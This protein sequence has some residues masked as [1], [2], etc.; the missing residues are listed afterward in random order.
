M[1]GTAPL[2]RL[3]V[4]RDEL[5]ARDWVI[6]CFGF[7]YKQ[8]HY[9]VLV[10][11]YV[12]PRKAPDRMLVQL[13]F[14]DAHDPTRTLTAPANTV[15]IAVDA[16]ELRVFLGISW[17]ENLGDLLAQFYA[18]LGRFVP[19]R[20]PEMLDAAARTVVLRE[21]SAGDS[22]DPNKVYCIG[23]RRNTE[24]ADGTPG[25]RS[26]YN[27]Q[28]TD[29]LRPDLYKHLRDDPNLSFRYSTNAGDEKSDAEILNQL[30][31]LRGRD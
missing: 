20:P 13:T 4:L 18:D 19:M 26:A 29:L 16:Q 25:R 31:E 28:K 1:T 10:E 9:F 5:V 12:P 22:E 27:S 30:A 21:L 17:S 24:R 15:R 8:Q 14:V 6:A 11:R 3:R 7:T 2:Q 23:V